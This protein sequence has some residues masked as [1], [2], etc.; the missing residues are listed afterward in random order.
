MHCGGV[1]PAL[2]HGLSA[3]D[4]AAFFRREERVVLGISSLWSRLLFLVGAPSCIGCGEKLA[5]DASPFCPRCLE[6]FRTV[7]NH[8]CGVCAAPLSRCTCAPPYMK[9]NGARKLIKVYRYRPDLSPDLPEKRLIFSL[10]RDNRRDTVAFAALLLAD[11]IRAAISHPES[12]LLVHVPR[13]TKALVEYGYDHAAALA[14]ATARILGASYL[15]LLRSESR[16][17][18]KQT[19]GEER[20]HNA[21]FRLK[22]NC[23]SLAGKTVLLVDDIVTTGASMVSSARL[24]RACHPRQIIPCTLAVAYRDPDAYR[25]AKEKRRRARLKRS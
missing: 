12:C 24:L 4:R 11:S 17:A 19:Q 15:P 2:C 5:E 16:K 25:A 9:A 8:T 14:K 1:S 20:L 18:Q 10:K 21:R 23:P 13:R 7:R 22:R 6:E 3:S